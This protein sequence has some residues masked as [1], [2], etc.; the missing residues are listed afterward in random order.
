[1]QSLQNNT[2]ETWGAIE[3]AAC[4]FEVIVLW[5]WLKKHYH[6]VILNYI[7]YTDFLFK[8]IKLV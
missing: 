2:L 6:E 4:L 5:T 8:K 1:M 3:G 7:G